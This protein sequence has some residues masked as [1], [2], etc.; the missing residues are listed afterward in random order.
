MWDITGQRP[1][2]F[3]PA[4]EW[5]DTYINDLPE[6]ITNMDRAE[7]RAAAE[8]AGYTW[9]A[10]RHAALNHRRVES[11]PA[12]GDSTVKRIWVLKPDTDLADDT[13]EGEAS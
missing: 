6:G 11:A 2:T 7:F 12:E 13:G 3:R 10:V 8:Q 1:T 4:I 5:V 9:T